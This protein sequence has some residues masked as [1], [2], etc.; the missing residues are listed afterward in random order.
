MV[1]AQLDIEVARK[2]PNRIGECPMWHPGEKA[3]YWIDTRA[4]VIHRLGLDGNTKVWN[5]P[6]TVGSFVF[7]RNG[8]IVA[9]TP[10]G[11]HTIDIETGKATLIVDPEPGMFQTKPNDGRC[12]RRGRYW[13]GTSDRE[14]AEPLG[15][16]YRLDP[17]FSCHTMDRGFIVG[18]C[19]GIS[20]DDRTLYYG[21]SRSDTVFAYDF[22]IDAGE[23]RNKRVFISTRHMHGRVDGA[24][25][26]A[27]GNYWGAM[28]HGAAVGCWDRNGRM[29][30]KIELPVRHPTMCCFGG[31]KLDILYVTTAS[32]MIMAAEK[33]SQP[34]AGC[35]FAVHGTG[36]TGVP[37]PFFGA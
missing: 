7:R 17:D 16:L 28:V 15:S 10:C 19:S 25:V 1:V 37:E 36:T 23:I 27:E 18:N 34:E 14:Q 12:D 8:G 3:L 6:F 35:L 21:D 22:D 24:T 13:C 5:L 31:E 2:I 9:A 32:I 33:T 26:D 20:P 29:I 30:R 4:P 11:F